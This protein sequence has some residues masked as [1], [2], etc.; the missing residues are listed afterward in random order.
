MTTIGGD[1]QPLWCLEKFSLAEVLTE[2][3]HAQL[4]K[5]MGA[6]SY[7]AGETILA[8]GEPTSTIYKLHVGHVRLGRVSAEGRQLTLVI[9]G[10]GELF[11][12][13]AFVDATS[14]RWSVEAIEDCVVCHVEKGVLLRLAERNPRLTLRLVKHIGDRT[15]ELDN[16][17]EDL[18]F[19]TVKGRLA[20][21][22]LRLAERH[23]QADEGGSVRVTVSMTHEEL[24]ELIAASREAT[25]VAVGELRQAS[26]IESSDGRFTL[27]NPIGLRAVR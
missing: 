2:E 13:M 1:G 25:S 11:G 16:K 26:L 6:Q 27:R 22:L 4:V 14:N 7:K 12:E 21:T 20:H 3:E 8:I 15:V 10:P 17:L 5:V 9:L 24:G 23:G 18:L 19:R